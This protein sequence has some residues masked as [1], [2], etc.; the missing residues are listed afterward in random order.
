[1]TRR[2]AL[3]L[4]LLSPAAALSQGTP[5]A[6]AVTIVP[7]TFGRDDCTS[8]ASV[9][10]TWTSSA[11]P[12]SPVAGNN[13]IYRV[14]V[15]TNTNC[16][17]TGTPLSATQLGSD[18]DAV[19]ATQSY[20]TALTRQSF[21]AEAGITACTADQTISVCVQHLAGGAAKA[22][23]S[24][25]A[26]LQVEPPPVPVNVV[27]APGDSALFVSWAAGTNSISGTNRIVAAVSY[28]VTAVVAQGN[29]LARTQNSVDRSHRID[30]LTNN[31]VYNVTVTSLSAGGNESAPSATVSGTPEPVSDFWDLY[32]KAK[33][34]EQGGCGGGPA[35]LVSLLGVALALRGL[36]RRS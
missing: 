16:P 9:G 33:G 8:T 25:S 11:T 32:A 21:I 17:A 2:L 4:A 1:M 35:G 20:L 22:V 5:A 12:A 31:T 26:E 34:P 10:L 30:G 15:S 19:T 13:E 18:I 14:W 27:V 28:N 6:G 36:R 23:A 7:D 3:I 29:T 24:G